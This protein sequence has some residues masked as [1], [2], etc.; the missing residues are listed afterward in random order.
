MNGQGFFVRFILFCFS[1]HL[2]YLDNTRLSWA[3]SKKCMSVEY[4]DRHIALV[5][6]CEHSLSLGVSVWWFSYGNVWCVN[7]SVYP[8]SFQQGEA[9]TGLSPYQQYAKSDVQG[10]QHSLCLMCKR[11]CLTWNP[12]DCWIIL[13]VRADWWSSSATLPLCVT[14]DLF[15]GQLQQTSVSV[16]W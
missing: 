1:L 13:P 9:G 5:S 12:A 2:E 3:T 16:I 15:R 7:N 14:T 8:G 11:A 4:L 10:T 6:V